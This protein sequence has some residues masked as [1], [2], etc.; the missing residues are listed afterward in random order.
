MIGFDGRVALVTGA[1]RG[2]G[3][4]HALDLARR[5]SCVAWELRI[6]TSVAKL[7]ILQARPIEARE[8]LAPVFAR[9]EEGFERRDLKVAERDGAE[10]TVYYLCPD[11]APPSGG[12][13]AIYRHVDLLNEAGVQRFFDR[14]DEGRY[15]PSTTAHGVSVEHEF[16]HGAAR[17]RRVRRFRG[18]ET[19]TAA[20]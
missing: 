18:R 5:Q 3:R 11:H 12:V 2:M 9:F 14:T 7:R 1:G 8:L 13:R 20:G 19:A 15:L 4:S 6:A 17:R 16:L 10:H